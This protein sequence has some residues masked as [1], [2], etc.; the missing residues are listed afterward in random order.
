[1]KFS[2]YQYLTARILTPDAE[3]MPIERHADMQARE[4]ASL[5]LAFVGDAVFHL[6]VREKLLHYDQ[7]NIQMLSAL[8]SE[9]VSARWQS[10]AYAVIE[11]TLTEAEQEIFRRARNAKSHAP[12]KATVAEY[13]RSTGFEALLGFLHL[14]GQEARLQEICEASFRFILQNLV[15]QKVMSPEKAAEVPE[16]KNT[17]EEGNANFGR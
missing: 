7:T 5:P 12:R 1:M 3:G 10:E 16:K 8:A 9:I 6:F 4:V 2:R 13:H 15:K 11:P 14:D 17:A